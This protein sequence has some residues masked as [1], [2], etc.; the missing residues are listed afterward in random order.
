MLIPLGFW[1]AS[2]SQGVG[3]YELIATANG[4]GSSNT[5]TFSSIPQ[6]Y[7]HLQ[8]R[9]VAR[10]AYGASIDTFYAYNFNNNTNSTGASYHLLYGTGS[11]VA[12]SAGSTGNFSAILGYV[13]GNN[14]VA[15]SH[16]VLITDIADYT[17]ITKNKTLRTFWGFTHSGEQ[18]VGLT[19]AVPFS[20][21]GTNAITSVS[22]VAN[23]NFTTS[24]RI[25]IYGI[26]G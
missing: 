5:I 19:S 14:A 6:T 3:S 21:L 2:G 4:T 15:N 18:Q 17:S 16:G 22:F 8:F 23:G 26:R 1:A 9:A 20:T 25:S 10:T 12:Q 24:T 7:K 11:G 13:S